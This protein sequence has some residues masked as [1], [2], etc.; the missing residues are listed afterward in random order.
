MSIPESR[1][2]SSPIGRAT[3][4]KEG[5]PP[6]PNSLRGQ[7]CTHRV[8]G[9]PALQSED[10]DQP[11][12]RLSGWPIRAWAIGCGSLGSAEL[13]DVQSETRQPYS[14]SSDGDGIRL[15]A[16]SC[17]AFLQSSCRLLKP[18]PA[19]AGAISPNIRAPERILRRLTSNLLKRIVELELTRNRVFDDEYRSAE[20][21]AAG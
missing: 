7:T 21:A 20:L 18:R 19:I 16:G 14:A 12:N 3:D 6:R 17:A 10:A 8:I 1:V 11:A 5:T 4:E 15:T 13:A 2:D 9:P